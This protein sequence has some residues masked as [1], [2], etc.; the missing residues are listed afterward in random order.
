MTVFCAG[1]YSSEQLSSVF[2][3]L[4]LYR[5]LWRYLQHCA[6]IVSFPYTFTVSCAGIYNS[7]H[8]SFSLTPLSYL[9]QAFTAV[10]IYQFLFLT[11]LP[12]LV[13]VFTAVSIYFFIFFLYLFCT[14]TVSCLGIH[15]SE[16]LFLIYFLL[17]PLV[18]LVQVCTTVC[19]CLLFCFL[20]F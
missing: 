12:Y 17:T 15:S 6:S 2:F 7:E 11:P 3:T 9:V 1:I 20:L 4:H 14:F 5:I 8:L 16:H 10:N 18:Y 19:I 13:Q